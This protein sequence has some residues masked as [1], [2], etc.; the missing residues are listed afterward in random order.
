MLHRSIFRCKPSRVRIRSAQL[1]T[2]STSVDRVLVEVRGF[3]PLASSMP[4]KRAT[5]CAIPPP[6]R[7][8]K[9]SFRLAR[10]ETISDRPFKSKSFDEV[11]A[12]AGGQLRAEHAGSHNYESFRSRARRGRGCSRSL[13]PT[14]PQHAERTRDRSASFG[15]SEPHRR[16]P[17]Q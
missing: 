17:V 2:R 13:R 15:Q 9:L 12:P 6:G 14:R 10:I 7:L 4:W 11:L 3:E 5:N 1:K 8:A 16:R